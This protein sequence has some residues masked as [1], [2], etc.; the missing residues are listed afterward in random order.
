MRGAIV[1]LLLGSGVAVELLCCVGLVRMRDAFDRL[2]Y[3]GP[4][5][6]LS[7]VMVA[8]AM[9]VEEGLGQPTVKTTLVALLL[10]ASS[11]VL[12]HAT[13]RAARVRQFDHWS[14]LEHEVVEE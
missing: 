14:A 5:S 3:L 8:T 9:L 10:V 11:P 2:H 13:G 4:A 12:S 1:A 7:P 6:T